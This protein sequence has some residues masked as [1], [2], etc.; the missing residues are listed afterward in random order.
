M[1]KRRK[2]FIALRLFLFRRTWSAATPRQPFTVS[3]NR[4]KIAQNVSLI[5]NV[6]Q[7]YG[8]RLP[9]LPDDDIDLFAYFEQVKN[10]VQGRGAVESGHLVTE[11]YVRRVTIR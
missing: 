8:L 2:N 11:S 9:T 1:K 6:K 3:F 4:D 5:E 7:D 10:A